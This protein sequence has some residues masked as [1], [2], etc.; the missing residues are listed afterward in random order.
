M[1]G[2]FVIDKPA[3]NSSFDVLRGLKK[4]FL[5]KKMGYL[6][7]LDP[8][9]TGVLVVFVGQATKLI[10]YFS[11]ADKEY[12]AELEFGKTSDTFDRTGHVERRTDAA[13]PTEEKLKE[14]L[15]HFLGQQWQIQPP[16]SAI[17]FKGQRAYELARAGETFDLGKRQVI[18]SDLQLIGYEPPKATLRVI[19]SS[20]T[21]IRSLI[22]EL[23]EQLEC[24]AIMTELRRT[25]VG[26]VVIEEAHS[27]EE[28]S[29]NNLL[30]PEK[31]ISEYIDWKHRSQQEKSFLLKKFSDPNKK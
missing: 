15:P 26:N 27:L 6:G 29:E 17:H 5:E 10:P 23:G 13:P 2:A 24:G 1:N 28:I 16:F 7:T 21:Y 8:L 14:A 30:S 18:I 4:R 31:I 3:G 19:C 12:V 20:G 22:H 9:A 25:R 11:E